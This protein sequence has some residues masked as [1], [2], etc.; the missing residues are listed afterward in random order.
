MK[1]SEFFKGT[2]AALGALA[3]SRGADAVPL[4][5]LLQDAAAGGGEDAFWRTVRDQFIL[6]PDWSYLNFG[7]L[8][9]MPL[10][11]SASYQEFS[12]LEEQAPTAGYAQKKW[13]GVKTKLARV[14]GPAC[15]RE[16]LA[17]IGCATEGI[18]MILNGLLLKK[19]D[20]VITSTH[21]HVALKCPLLNR[22]Q[23]DG[24]VIRLFDPDLIKSSG[25]VERIA[26][27]VN[28]RTRLIFLSHVTCTAGQVFPVKE[29]AALAREK[30]IWFALDG[31]QGPA[32]VPFDI[33]ADGVDFYTSSAHKWLM[34]PKRTGFLYVRQG[35][36]D[37]LRPTVTGAG[38]SPHHDLRTGEFVLEPNAAR[39]EYG[40]QNEALF[41][42]LGE[43]LDFIEAIGLPRILKYSRGLAETFYA[44]LKEIPGVDIL[45]PAEEA[46]RSCMISFRTARHDFDEINCRMMNARI[47]VRQVSENDLN[48]IRVSFYIC[49]NR[50]D[51]DHI[52]A[53]LKTLA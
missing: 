12:R 44:G 30:G 8:G 37:V 35:M 33:V 39:Y 28:A 15:R 45:S 50:A 32:C 21:E 17:L 16:D 47:R 29:I 48:C 1:R 36:L 5:R 13:D 6:D 43:A 19:G 40:T 23:A 20:E 2:A 27:L 25:N 26:G 34:G 3:L 53:T 38:S 22:L 14:L 10:P 46:Y 51:V 41:F 24:I 4:R 9:S 18:N 31:A 42:A 52:L 7:G 11:V 49:N